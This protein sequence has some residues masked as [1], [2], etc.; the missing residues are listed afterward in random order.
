MKVVEIC[1]AA[2]PPS[3]SCRNVRGQTAPLAVVVPLHL[4]TWPLQK[5]TH[6]VINRPERHVLSSEAGSHRPPSPASSLRVLAPGQALERG[7]WAES[8]G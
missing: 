8:S 7:G 2:R 3:V 4:C 1:P 5:T 6:S